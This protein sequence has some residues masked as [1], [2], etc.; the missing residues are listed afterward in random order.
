M[1]SK[2][3][4]RLSASPI[5]WL[6]QYA[7]ENPDTISLAAGLVEEESLP[8]DEF[9]EAISEIINSDEVK[10]F[11]QYGTTQGLP[12]L[13]TEIIKWI[14]E[15]ESTVHSPL[16]IQAEDVVVTNGSQQLLYLISEAILDPG[17]IVLIESPSYFV[18]A[19]TLK[20]M[21]VKFEIINTDSE[22]ISAQDLDQALTKLSTSGQLDRVKM[23]YT[24]PW[25][26]N[27]SGVSRSLA[28][29]QELRQ[30]LESWIVK[31][32]FLILEDAAYRSLCF[33][34]E[35]V[36]STLLQS[37]IL[38]SYVAYV[39]TFSKPFAPGIKLGAGILPEELLKAVLLLKGNH[40]F[41]SSHWNQAVLWKL[42]EKGLLKQARDRVLESYQG[43][44][45]LLYQ[46]LRDQLPKEFLIEKPTGGMYLWI[47]CPSHLK[48]TRDSDLFKNAL[49]EKV[50]FVPGEYCD[51]DSKNSD[52][53]MRL[54]Y[55]R[56]NEK[57]I[58]IGAERLILAINRSLS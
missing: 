17:D 57:E 31:H 15:I 21:G 30:V 32:P 39:T 43:K 7:L 52:H 54:S 47:Q 50:L 48:T 53:S 2:K 14:Q 3:T 44:A 5:N 38:K 46:I 4:E 27:P 56:V 18:Y 33:E 24:I 25:A 49:D 41:G 22:G 26:Q 10:S 51:L 58:K 36:S 6:I 37:Q 9:S 35:Q 45:K 55:G 40:D 20:S 13:K 12:R 16:D 19:D 23:L 28:R 8:V 1:L 11:L 34:P 42:L 29:E